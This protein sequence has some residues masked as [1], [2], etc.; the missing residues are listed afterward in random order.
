MLQILHAVAFIHQE[1]YAHLDIKL[2]NILLDGKF[3][4]KLADMGASVN[5]RETQG[6]TTKRRGTLLYMAPEVMNK[7]SA[8]HFNALN[9]DIFSLGI[10]LF[11][12]LIGEFPSSGELLNNSSTE[13]SEKSTKVPFK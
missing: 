12:L 11:V 7:T 13:D 2:E 9:A 4:I 8:S 3:N 1:G 6:F 5:V 10:T